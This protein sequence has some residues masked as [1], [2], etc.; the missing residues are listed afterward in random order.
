MKKS[1]TWPKLTTWQNSTTGPDSTT[2]K[3][4]KVEA[5]KLDI[6]GTASSLW[7]KA[8]GHA[9]QHHKEILHKY[10]KYSDD[11]SKKI[12]PKTHNHF[13]SNGLCSDKY[14]CLTVTNA[15]IAHIPAR[16]GRTVKPVGEK[17]LSELL[18]KL[19]SGKSHVHLTNKVHKT[20]LHGGKI[21]HKGVVIHIIAAKD[22]I[23]SK[24]LAGYLFDA[25]KLMAL[26]K[27]P[28]AIRAVRAQADG[29]PI[30]LVSVCVY[31]RHTDKEMV[32]NFCLGIDNAQMQ[33]KS[34]K[35]VDS[36]AKDSKKE[37]PKDDPKRK[38]ELKENAKPKEE[39]KR[40]K[41]EAAPEANPEAAAEA[42]ADANAKDLPF[43]GFSPRIG[44]VT[45]PGFGSPQFGQMNDVP[46]QLQERDAEPNRKRSA[47]AEADADAD[48]SF[49]S[50]MGD[51]GK[52]L[53]MDA[54]MMMVNSAFMRHSNKKQQQQD[55]GSGN[56][57]APAPAPGGSR[58]NLAERHA[59]PKAKH[60]KHTIWRKKGSKSV[61]TASSYPPGATPKY[62]S[63]HQGGKGR[64]GLAKP[65]A[66]GGRLPVVDKHLAHHALNRGP[67][68]LTGAAS[69]LQ[70]ATGFAP[71]NRGAAGAM[72]H[73]GGAEDYGAH[74]LARRS[75]RLG[76]FGALFKKKNKGHKGRKGANMRNIPAQQNGAGPLKMPSS[77]NNMPAAH[78]QFYQQ[79]MGGMGGMGGMD[80][81][82]NP[83]D[84][85][86]SHK[87][88]SNGGDLLNGAGTVM[89]AA[90]GFAT[91]RAGGGMGA[92]AGGFGGAAEGLG[93]SAASGMMSKRNLEAR[94]APME[95]EMAKREVDL[96][97]RTNPHYKRFVAGAGKLLANVI[98]R[99][100][101]EISADDV[102]L[103]ARDPKKRGFIKKLFRK[104]THGLRKVAGMG[105]SVVSPTKR[106]MQFSKREGKLV[107]RDLEDLL[108]GD[109][110][111]FLKRDGTE[112]T[113][114]DVVL[115]A[116]DPTINSFFHNLERDVEHIVKRHATSEG[117]TSAAHAEILGSHVAQEM[118]KHQ[119][120]MHEVAGHFISHRHGKNPAHYAQFPQFPS[121]SPFAPQFAARSL[122]ERGF[123]RAPYGLQGYRKAYPAAE[124][125]QGATG[126]YEQDGA[127]GTA[128]PQ[129]IA[130]MP[131]KPGTHMPPPKFALSERS[132]GAADAKKDEPKKDEPTKDEPKKDEPKKDEPKKDVSQK[133]EPEKPEKEGPKKASPTPKPK[134]A[135]CKAGRKVPIFGP[136]IGRGCK[137]ARSL[138]YLTE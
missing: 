24:A 11:T 82:G 39:I 123:R 89:Q 3:F 111:G 26:E 100:G 96:L 40:G 32:K 6:N 130:A 1:T 31:P 12:G 60:G 63:R 103:W 110:H 66:R 88:V 70:A 79:D 93:A 30:K 108:S 107:A 4:A 124:S 92:A 132:A 44:V 16:T 10:Q 73:G 45:K 122:D 102:K 58:K 106:D 134:P 109:L 125:Q 52:N 80:M 91:P 43:R 51:M 20:F 25:W 78:N 5:L 46:G 129:F 64:G 113:P 136:V 118:R 127:A 29:K 38:D 15:S 133:P 55:Q 97:L 99:D 50:M 22:R 105:K 42:V 71:H 65:N 114:V 115:M 56:G 9:F 13:S 135:L 36:K 75:F 98:K 121:S 81:Y 54:P 2:G 94:A 84:T 128:T 67:E 23:R 33:A 72:G 34:T 116:R 95:H 19:V 47:E 104:V 61:T 69:V 48:P 37:G 49:L 117:A 17:D 77:R 62:G 74:G 35:K 68:L 119:K 87:V 131:P 57:N 101:T 85:K 76:R 112:M 86:L 59:E 53:V 7:P 8:T 90:Q 126:N 138:G 28:T 14:R 137:L 27:E 21:K 18:E 41:R 83:Q 120:G